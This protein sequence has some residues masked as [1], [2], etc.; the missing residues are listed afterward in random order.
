MP[1]PAMQE[2]QRRGGRIATDVGVEPVTGYLAAVRNIIVHWPII[3]RARAA[4]A[5]VRGQLSISTA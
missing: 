2:Q 1:G 5:D 4:A 3:T